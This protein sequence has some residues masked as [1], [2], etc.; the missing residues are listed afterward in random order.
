M[1]SDPTEFWFVVRTYEYCTTTG[2]RKMSFFDT[3]QSHV[4]D[5]L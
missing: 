5:Y 4:K 3:R 2:M 1:L